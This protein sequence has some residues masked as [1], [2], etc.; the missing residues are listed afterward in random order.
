M[1]KKLIILGLLTAFLTAPTA[2]AASAKVS[3]N[4]MVCAFCAQG[5]KKKFSDKAAVEKVDV[6]LDT[7][8]VSL[9][10]KKDQKLSDEEI[11][12]AIKDA[13]YTV[14]KIERAE[15]P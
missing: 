1:T 8:V 13:G 9:D 14:V 7:K 5:I 11:T 6:N 2:F 12:Q 4:G 15:K 3:V 10:F